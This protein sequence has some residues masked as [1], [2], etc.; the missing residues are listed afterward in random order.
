MARHYWFPTFSTF[1]HGNAE[2]RRLFEKL[3]FV[4]LRL[5]FEES[6]CHGKCGGTSLLFAVLT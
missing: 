4:E 1:T 6:E 2:A 5:Q 3:A